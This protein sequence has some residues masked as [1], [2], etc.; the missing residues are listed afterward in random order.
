[1]KDTW[2]LEAVVEQDKFKKLKEIGRVLLTVPFSSLRKRMTTVVKQDNGKIRLFIKGTPAKIL[3]FCNYYYNDGDLSRLT[4]EK[5][6]EILS[7]EGVIG[8][9]AE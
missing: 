2:N 7:A 3:P 5:R 6:E 4:D 1:L 9:M 8:K